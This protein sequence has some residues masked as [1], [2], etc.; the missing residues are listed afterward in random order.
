MELLA[1]GFMTVAVGWMA[2]VSR[3]ILMLRVQVLQLTIQQENTT[4][5]KAKKK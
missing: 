1:G 5:T 3:E 4:K 2:W